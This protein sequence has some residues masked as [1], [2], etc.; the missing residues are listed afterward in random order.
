M[1]PGGAVPLGQNIDR[2]GRKAYNIL[3]ENNGGDGGAAVP[4]MK[5]GAAAER[6]HLSAEASLS[7][8]HSLNSMPAVPGR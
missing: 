1:E 3:L 8:C 4:Y 2:S 7:R 5:S 6:W